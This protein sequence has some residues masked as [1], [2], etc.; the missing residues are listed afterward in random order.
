MGEMTVASFFSA[1]GETV[2][3][4]IT[5]A[6]N[7][8]TGLWSSGIAGQIICSLGFAGMAIGFGCGIFAIG[9]GLKRRKK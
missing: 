5:S 7:V 3:G 4:L 2:T 9:K 8:F 6:V 1:V